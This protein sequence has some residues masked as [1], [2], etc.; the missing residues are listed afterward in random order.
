MP[1]RTTRGINNV[2]SWGNSPGLRVRS[3]VARECS[4]RGAVRIL[5]CTR[6]SRLYRRFAARAPPRSGRALTLGLMTRG[7]LLRGLSGTKAL[8][9]VGL[10]VK[11]AL[12]TKS[13][14]DG[15]RN[16]VVRHQ[17]E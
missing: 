14:S 3:L 2:A 17:F 12:E 5:A 13:I 7:C 10:Q 6:E 8:I 15:L 16:K 9:G 1:H 4:S 11:I